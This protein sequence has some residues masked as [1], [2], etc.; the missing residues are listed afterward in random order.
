MSFSRDSPGE[1]KEKQGLE[2]R[3]QEFH[4]GIFQLPPTPESTGT[5]VSS[6]ALLKTGSCLAHC[7]EEQRANGGW[8][9]AGAMPLWTC[10]QPHW[11]PPPTFLV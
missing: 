8:C 10:P 7:L 1:R 5:D 3:W 2:R 9:R 11:L 6:W 4:T